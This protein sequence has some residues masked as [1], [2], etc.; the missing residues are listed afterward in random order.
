MRVT[1]AFKK[2]EALCDMRK[3]LTGSAPLRF[4]QDCAK[5]GNDIR[6]LG[7]REIFHIIVKSPV[8]TLCRQQEDMVILGVCTKVDTF[9][10]AAID[11][12]PHNEHFQRRLCIVAILSRIWPRNKA[13][14]I[15]VMDLVR[16]AMIRGSAV[17]IRGTQH[18]WR[19]AITTRGIDD[20]YDN[21]IGF[22]NAEDIPHATRSLFSDNRHR[23]TTA[24]DFHHR[25]DLVVV[26]CNKPIAK[27]EDS[28]L[29]CVWRNNFDAV[30]NRVSIGDI[31]KLSS[32]EPS[33]EHPL[34]GSI[35]PGVYAKPLRGSQSQN[36]V[37]DHLHALLG[38]LY[39]YSSAK[40][41]L[42]L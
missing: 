9:D 28:L 5:L 23:Y 27:D 31:S 32:Q 33:L 29:H 17:G 30:L 16:L 2:Y 4:S 40:R 14:R 35:A 38:R 41:V 36:T 20:F 7:M 13:E 6:R 24:D 11:Y 39:D 42:F 25:F 8:A 26:V 3:L 10:Y 1:I 37:D 15:T 34:R 22:A 18:A 21:R 19:G 12:A